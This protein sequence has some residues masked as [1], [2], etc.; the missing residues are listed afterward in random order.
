MM[1]LEPESTKFTNVNLPS[2]D[3]KLF[4]LSNKTRE[5]VN[6]EVYELESFIF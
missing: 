4:N 2:D 3:C 6:I 5:R 1:D